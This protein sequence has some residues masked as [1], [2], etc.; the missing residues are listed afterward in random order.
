MNTQLKKLAEQAGAEEL[1][2][3][4][5]GGPFIGAIR[6]DFLEEF[7]KLILKE[8]LTDFYRN[9]L[10]LQSDLVIEVQVKNYVEDLFKE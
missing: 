1:G 7:A 9:H 4:L 10:D 3:S 5:W 2:C 6:E 8:K